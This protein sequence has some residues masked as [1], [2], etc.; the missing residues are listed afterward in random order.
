MGCESLEVYVMSKDLLMSL[1]EHCIAH[2][3]PSFSQ[4]ALLD[5]GSRLKLVSYTFEGHAARLSFPEEAVAVSSSKPS[6]HC[7]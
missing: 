7:P 3:I 2:N 5:M 6:S 1:V 4:G